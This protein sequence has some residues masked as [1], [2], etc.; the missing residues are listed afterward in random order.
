M[1][2]TDIND[3]EPQTLLEI[4]RLI[5]AKQCA[6]VAICQKLWHSLTS[7]DS[8][9]QTWCQEEYLLEQAVTPS[10]QPQNTWRGAYA[11]WHAD[12]SKYKSY[13]KRAIVAW[14]TIKHWTSS[15]HPEIY[16]SLGL[17]ATESQLDDA[18]RTLGFKLPNSLRVIY[19][20]HNGQ[21]LKC[22]EEKIPS[23]ALDHAANSLFLGLLGGYSFYDHSV[24]TRL[25][26]IDKA[27]QNTVLLRKANSHIEYEDSVQLTCSTYSYKHF[28]VMDQGS[29]MRV[30]SCEE[31][32]SWD[33]V[34]P[35]G[36]DAALRWLEAFADKLKYQLG[37]SALHW[38]T[39]LRN[40]HV[41]CLYP[42]KQPWEKVAVT[43][44]VRVQATSIFV[45]ELSKQ[46]SKNSEEAYF[47]S[48]KVQFSLLS[49]EEQAACWPAS[50]GPFISPVTSVQ[51][52][53]RHWIIRDQNGEVTEDVAGDGVI[54]RYPI[55][56]PG[57][58]PFVYQ[59]C[60]HQEQ[61]KGSMEG[62]FRFVEG[63][64]R[65]PTGPVFD[66]ECPRFLLEKPEYVF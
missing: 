20:L 49:V 5:P 37:C 50:A 9:W 64:S 33:A 16:E 18:E 11:A 14:R 4:F 44:G 59:S 13:A 46:S 22:D 51:L 12:F 62:S 48:Y 47:F 56:V 27:V 7:D 32:R 15:H 57:C 31:E 28:M 38:H 8:L 36:H 2:H 26:P 19:R 24:C 29:Q 41:I 61:P 65:H 43:Q 58:V 35:G 66:V 1:E 17:P 42:V 25:M 30:A 53:T 3:L 52:Q 40:P 60:T 63:T 23:D 45:P 39:K 54:G 10:G 6:K 34:P 21:N 55:L